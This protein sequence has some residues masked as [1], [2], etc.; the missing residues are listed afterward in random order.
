MEMAT[1]ALVCVY[2]ICM[3][4]IFESVVRQAGEAAGESTWILKLH[5]AEAGRALHGL[6]YCT[7][8]SKNTGKLDPTTFVGRGKII[9]V[10]VITDPRNEN[11]K[12]LVFYCVLEN[13]HRVNVHLHN[14]MRYKYYATPEDLWKIKPAQIEEVCGKDFATAFKVQGDKWPKKAKLLDWVK[15]TGILCF[16]CFSSYLR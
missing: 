2:D 15:D 3:C 8:P 1:Y 13:T 14:Q 7:S 10:E 6:H 9:G 5:P 16:L 11:A 4:F 12:C